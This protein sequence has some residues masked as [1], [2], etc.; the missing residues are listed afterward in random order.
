MDEM[1]LMKKLS[2][3]PSPGPEA[4]DRARTALRAAMDEPATTT[5]RP[6]RRFSWPRAGMATAGAA[7]VAAA[8]VAA[9]VVLAPAGGRGG[10]A[11]S[12]QAAPPVVDS[13][14]VKLAAAVG[15]GAPQTGDASLVISTKRAPDHSLEVYYTIYSDKGQ[16]FR[17]DSERTL[18]DSVA[19]ND[20][21][22]TEFNRKVMAAARLAAT[23]DVEKAKAGMLTAA[24]RNFLGIGLSLAEAEREWKQAR[25]EVAEQFRRLGKEPPPVTPRPTG[26]EL[27]DLMANHLWSNSTSALFTGAA[28]AEVRAGVL[29][30]LATMKDVVT[31][32]ESDVGGRR[33]LTISAVP[34]ILGGDGSAVLTLDAANG[35][36][37]SDEY[38]PAPNAPNPSKPAVVDYQSSRVTLADVAAGKI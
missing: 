34:G 9:A 35:L 24:N 1:D 19:R 6:R 25:E 18:S 5:V 13:P 36:P 7:A 12:V 26:K 29:K 23:G 4:Y 37:I 20:D 33:V 17:G 11:D 38:I 22:A 3:V 16:V 31:V 10:P 14:L 30:L 21:Q 28:N 2:D 27:D 15:A 8:V 32:A